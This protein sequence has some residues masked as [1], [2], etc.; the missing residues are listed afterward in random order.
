MTCLAYDLGSHD[1]LL[2]QDT[3]P[4]Q[5]PPYNG[6]YYYLGGNVESFLVFVQQEL[7]A[8]SANASHLVRTDITDL[9][10]QKVG[11]HPHAMR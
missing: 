7:G 2:A 4:R 3:R 10:A 1:R 8:S 5:G 11:R 6:S 9:A